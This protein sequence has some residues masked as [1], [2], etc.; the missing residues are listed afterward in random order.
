VRPVVIGLLVLGLIVLLIA[1]GSAARDHTGDTVGASTWARDVCG[2]VSAYE[3][4][5]KD[6][7]EDFQKNNYAAR[8][9][10]GGSGDSV[11]NTV[12]VRDAVDR[13]IIAT[14]ETLQRG[15][16]RAGQ[17]NSPKG[18]QAA[19]L[20]Q[21]WGQQT[22]NNLRVAQQKIKHDPA[23]ASLSSQYFEAVVAPLRAL[24][25][26]TAQ[27]RATF[28]AVGALDPQLSSALQGSS[29]CQDLK[30]DPA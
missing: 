3:G 6:I 12:T 29:R 22:E 7:R 21:R 13:A 9:L 26:S 14:T 16:E 1:A 28:Q 2:T 23:N 4:A 19:A 25:R 18:K 5:L 10:D 30:E 27:G 17:P 11:E 20:L 8:R 15:L 24:A